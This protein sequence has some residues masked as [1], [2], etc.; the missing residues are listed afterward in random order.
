MLAI[1]RRW[2]SYL[3]ELVLFDAEQRRRMHLLE[4]DKRIKAAIDSDALSEQQIEACSDFMHGR[5]DR[6]EIYGRV[7]TAKS[8]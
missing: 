5:T 6:V 7:I 1:A 3:T 2:L 4:A 8:I